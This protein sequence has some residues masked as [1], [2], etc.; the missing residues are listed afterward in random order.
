MMQQQLNPLY[1]LAM[2]VLVR[3]IIRPLE[4]LGTFNANAMHLLIVADE[5]MRVNG[6]PLNTGFPSTTTSSV[7]VLVTMVWAFDKG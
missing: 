4:V 7:S 1:A 3:V 2:I 5:A 6:A